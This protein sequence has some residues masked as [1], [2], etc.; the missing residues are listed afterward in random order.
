MMQSQNSNQLEKVPDK[1]IHHHFLRE[2]IVVGIDRCGNRSITQDWIRLTYRNLLEVDGCSEL[3]KGATIV[4][5]PW[6]ALFEHLILVWK[7]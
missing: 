4:W 6:M 3:K 5:L 7:V 1:A 2:L